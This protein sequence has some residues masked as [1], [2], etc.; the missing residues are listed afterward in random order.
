MKFRL[1]YISMI[2]FLFVVKS[3]VLANDGNDSNSLLVTT[4]WLAEHLEEPD[5]II[6][7]IGMKAEYEKVHVPGARLFSMKEI[8]HDPVDGFKHEISPAEKLDSVLEAAGITNESR[9][10]IYYESE[11]GITAAGRVYVTLDFVGLGNNTSILDGGLPQWRSENRPISA[12]FPKVTPV[13]FTPQLNNDVLVNTNWVKEN[14]RNPEIVIID[15]RP[16]EAYTGRF[17]DRR[18]TRHGHITG[19]FYLPFTDLTIESE[20]HK[21]KSAAELRNMFEN[22][23]AKPNSILVTYCDTG[24]WACLVYFVAKHLGY[25]A[26]FYDAGWEAWSADDSLPMTKPVKRKLSR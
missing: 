15:T 23:G 22:A 7:H 4:D 11:R 2:V 16:E 18:F 17:R 10:V 26:R 1:I 12:D 5:L 19:A 9:I 24:Y 8:M 21:F 3:E 6:L 20:P 25:D 14:L 13:D